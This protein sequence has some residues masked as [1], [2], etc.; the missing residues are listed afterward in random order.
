MP[1][2]T[3]GAEFK[4]FYGDEQFW[5]EKA[6]HEDAVIEVDGKKEDLDLFAIPDTATVKIVEGVVFMDQGQEPIT[7][8]TFFKRWRKQQNTRTLMVE[9]DASKLDAL[10]AA[11]KAAGGKVL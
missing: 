9:V 6:W 11:I 10:V 3:N 8:E 1:V 5:P 7:L 2:S 4:R